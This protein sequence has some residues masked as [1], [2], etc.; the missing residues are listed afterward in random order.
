MNKVTTITSNIDPSQHPALITP[1]PSWFSK[2]IQKIID[3]FQYLFCCCRPG[4]PAPITEHRVVLIPANQAPA[5]IAPI[6]APILLA[7]P[8]A[9]QAPLH[10]LKTNVVATSKTRM[11]FKTDEK[12]GLTT[13]GPTPEMSHKLAAQFLGKGYISGARLQSGIYAF[14][15]ELEGGDPVEIASYLKF[16]LQGQ[17]VK[18]GTVLAQFCD[19]VIA[20][21]EAREDSSRTQFAT[22][23]TQKI[24]HMQPGDQFLVPGGWQGKSGGHALMLFLQRDD[25]GTFTVNVINSGDGAQYHVMKPLS[26]K[27]G[28]K[29]KALPYLRQSQISQKTLS[30]ISVWEFFHDFE[31]DKIAENLPLGPRDFYEG[32]FKMLHP[33]FGEAQKKQCLIEPPADDVFITL[34]AAGTCSADAFFA[35]THFLLKDNKV[36][37][38][39]IKHLLKLQIIQDYFAF[40]KQENVFASHEKNL[41][42]DTIRERYAVLKLFKTY[43]KNFA[44]HVR[45]CQENKWISEQDA[46]ACL[47]LS[48]SMDALTNAAF[49]KYKELIRTAVAPFT[50]LS[51]LPL[52]T[53]P[54][55]KDFE[56][57]NEYKSDP[58]M[59]FFVNTMVDL[60]TVWPKDPADLLKTLQSWEKAANNNKIS[61]H[62]IYRYLNQVIVN[63]PPPG[64][65]WEAVPSKE[66]EEV[67]WLIANLCEKILYIHPSGDLPSLPVFN[68]IYQMEKAFAVVLQL[69]KIFPGEDYGL[70][71]CQINTSPFSYNLF[72]SNYKD[73]YI[74]DVDTDLAKQAM[75]A[76]LKPC[77]S[78]FFN[79]GTPWESL[80]DDKLKGYRELDAKAYQSSEKAFV[81]R[82]L[83]NNKQAYEAAKKEAE[84]LLQNEPL[85]S[86]F[87]DT[88]EYVIF[89]TALSDV[90]GTILP[91]GYCALKKTAM[92]KSLFQRRSFYWGASL[93]FKRKVEIVENGVIFCFKPNMSGNPRYF[94][95]V[96]QLERLIDK[97]SSNSILLHPRF[98]LESELQLIFTTED[99]SHQVLKTLLF[100]KKH[101]S[102]LKQKKYQYI[103]KRLMF[104]HRLLY[105]QLQD[106]PSF[107]QHLVEF[108]QEGFKC[109]LN[110]KQPTE[111]LFFLRIGSYFEK[112]CQRLSIKNANFPNLIQVCD[113]LITKE[114]KEV[115]SHLFLREQLA[116]YGRCTSFD[117]V[118]LSKAIATLIEYVKVKVQFD[119]ENPHFNLELR[120]DII[121]FKIKLYQHFKFVDPKSCEDVLTRATQ[122][123]LNQKEIAAINWDLSKMPLVTGVNAQTKDRYDIDLNVGEFY[124]NEFLISNTLSEHFTGSA[125]FKLIYDRTPRS[126]LKNIKVGKRGNSVQFT[127]QNNQEIRAS[128]SADASDWVIQKLIDNRWHTHAPGFVNQMLDVHFLDEWSY[129]AWREK[130]GKGFQIHQNQTGREVYRYQGDSQRLMAVDPQNLLTYHLSL[131]APSKSKYHSLSKVDCNTNLWQDDLG[132]V[133]AIEYPFGV[134]FKVEYEQG[135][136]DKKTLKGIFVDQPASLQGYFLDPTQSIPS[137][138]RIPFYLVLNNARGEKIVL[139]SKAKLEYGPSLDSNFETPKGAK[140]FYTYHVN[141]NEFLSCDDLEGAIYLIRIELA[142]RNYRI[143]HEMLR[144]PR[145]NK[146]TLYSK[147]EIDPSLDALEIVE[148][149][150]GKFCLLNVSDEDPRAVSLRLKIAYLLVK[151]LNTFASPLK[152]YDGVLK[153][154][155]ERCGEDFIRYLSNM[156]AVGSYALSPDE[157][158]FLLNCMSRAVGGFSNLLLKR[159]VYERINKSFDSK[160][161]YFQLL[162]NPEDAAKDEQSHKSEFV[163]SESGGCN[164]RRM[165]DESYITISTLENIRNSSRWFQFNILNLYAVAISDNIHSTNYLFL[166]NLLKI[167]IISPLEFIRTLSRFCINVMADKKSYP[168]VEDFCE[169]LDKIENQHLLAYIKSEFRIRDEPL[170]QPPP[171]LTLSGSFSPKPRAPKVF[172][173]IIRQGIVRLL[174]PL[175][176]PARLFGI[177]LTETP[178][179]N[180]NI[181]STEKEWNDVRTRIKLL[182]DKTG[183]PS[184]KEQKDLEELLDLES[185]LFQQLESAADQVT[186][187]KYN[188]IAEELQRANQRIDADDN[189]DEMV[190][191]KD[192]LLEFLK[193]EAFFKAAESSESFQLR[194]I[195]HQEE[196][197]KLRKKIDDVSALQKDRVA[198]RTL[199]EL[200]SDVEEFGK[201]PLQPIL[202]LNTT[203]L[204]KMESNLQKQLDFETEKLSIAKKRLLE[205]ANRPP[206]DPKER[207]E[208]ELELEAGIRQK[209]TL[210]DL[211]LKYIRGNSQDFSPITLVNEIENYLIRATRRQ[212]IERSLKALGKFTSLANTEDS[213]VIQAAT[214][215]LYLQ[216]STQ[217]AYDPKQYPELLVTE[218][219]KNILYR[220]EQ[221]AAYEAIL[222]AKKPEVYQHIMGFGKTEAILP[223]LALRK[224]TGENLVCI[225]VAEAQIKEL[226]ARMQINSG[227]MYGQVANRLNWSD[228][229]LDNLKN[230]YK[231]LQRIIKN[232]EF[233][234]V[235]DQE[236]HDFFLQ[237][238]LVRRNRESENA[239][240]EAQGKM[241]EMNMKEARQLVSLPLNRLAH[242]NGIR[243]LLKTKGYA[244][245]DEIDAILRCH[246][247]TLIAVGNPH[248]VNKQAADAAINVFTILLGNF[249]IVKKIYFEFYRHRLG[250]NA[251]PFTLERYHQEVKPI[252]LKALTSHFLRENPSFSKYE[253]DIQKYLQ[254][255]HSPNFTQVL[256]KEF[257]AEKLEELAN[258]R[259]ALHVFLPMTLNQLHNENYG[260]FPTANNGTSTLAGPYQRADTPNIGSQFSHVMAQMF[261]TIQSY[262]KTGITRLQVAA[263]I[264]TLK[265]NIQKEMS[266]SSLITL[267]KT[268]TYQTFTKLVG[269]TAAKKLPLLLL[270]EKDYDT[271][272]THIQ[273]APSQL[274]YYIQHYVFP[275]ISLFDQRIYSNAQTL[276]E[277]FHDMIGVTGTID[278]AET[279]HTRLTTIPT[280]GVNG[281]TLFLMWLNRHQSVRVLPNTETKPLVLLH[282]IL[283]GTQNDNYRVLLDAGAFFKGC[284]Q[285][286][287]A[288]EIFKIYP[289]TAIEAVIFFENDKL[290]LI[291][292][293]APNAVHYNKKNDVP[294]DK[295]FTILPQKHCRAT[296]IEQALNSQALMT[297]N[298]NM[299]RSDA[300][301]SVWRMRGLAKGQKVTSVIQPDLVHIAAQSLQI[302]EK[303]L[304][305]KALETIDLQLFTALNHA[306]HRSEDNL[307]SIHQKLQNVVL[308]AIERLLNHIDVRED[309]HKT[310]YRTLDDLTLQKVGMSA[311]QQFGQSTIEE[312]RKV[313]ET[314]KRNCLTPLVDWIT[315]YKDHQDYLKYQDFQIDVKSLVNEMDK[316]IDES[317]QKDQE[318]VNEQ[319]STRLDTTQDAAVKVSVQMK[320]VEKEREREQNMEIQRDFNRISSSQSAPLESNL[321]FF[322][323]KDLLKTSIFESIRK[324][325][326]LAQKGMELNIKNNGDLRMKKSFAVVP[327]Y[328]RRCINAGNLFPLDLDIAEYRVWNAFMPPNLIL[329][330]NLIYSGE[331]DRPMEPIAKPFGMS[332]IIQ[333]KSNPNN[334]MLIGLSPS[335][336]EQVKQELVAESQTKSERD[337]KEDRDNLLCLYNPG[338][339][340]YQ[341]G[342]EPMDLTIVQNPHFMVLNVLFKFLNGEIYYNDEELKIL[343]SRLRKIGG[344]AIIKTIFLNKLIRNKDVY[345]AYP[346]SPLAAL[347]KSLTSKK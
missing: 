121:A 134:S 9:P 149:E 191:F 264:Q 307:L 22:W 193:T 234:L 318:Y 273:A 201:E 236:L 243:S 305:E 27:K 174:P 92:T 78:G 265:D 196:L 87:K 269:E 302:D 306:Q 311:Y 220:A 271:I 268:A 251:Q 203:Q 336:A 238:R 4:V 242:F 57:P 274:L 98:G 105:K 202:E 64:K 39:Q 211:Y 153:S 240:K 197:S 133:A 143:T 7:A 241:R 263:L 106:E 68:Q 84:L 296:D 90:T 298:K 223:P 136:N 329:T 80:N 32:F 41:S 266:K 239:I 343:E 116:F 29:M 342:K 162:Q 286:E 275:S 255:Q 325:A 205:A 6:I 88:P 44:K 237:A 160:A 131:M 59:D 303:Q 169:R 227:D 209:V 164:S 82:Y 89:G 165:K 323:L 310:L 232:R 91:K 287:L 125:S 154:V 182:Y 73:N 181:E 137:L 183:E 50:T 304:K 97:H 233:L 292:R 332:L 216:L 93:F 74:L 167:S 49:R 297:W 152:S 23:I 214:Q 254:D 231:D 221:I 345:A 320:Q 289:K 8:A 85:K 146:L 290:M 1:P 145:M 260:F 184:E 132:Y 190:A 344:I 83:Q 253:Q 161:N 54:L 207:L 126:N 244:I 249:N 77:N 198:K 245:F 55:T 178:A 76:T 28:H 135:E 40:L 340:I 321:A 314:C 104:E 168:D 101:L 159:R 81:F 157:E 48:K 63:M 109:F 70:K 284:E 115:G 58:P 122:M 20:V 36:L 171:T 170:A 282:Q 204:P 140:G 158:L 247:E 347:F 172:I 250:D 67:M 12:D 166:Q 103:F 293:D 294:L 175:F 2:L 42:I 194:K 129:S 110:Q 46:K 312:A 256:V 72:G 327:G 24:Q 272:A 35:F 99:Q 291:K 38:K 66:M 34:Q 261:F 276:P 279:F 45:N 148:V 19:N 25:D 144:D 53:F 208:F 192:H 179:L 313:L 317:L 86:H 309:M 226:S 213:R 324:E 96:T 10:P 69:S 224:T 62:E 319:L 331:Y 16:I 13:R 147:P 150:A 206:L 33:T 142:Q 30:Q 151:N 37:Y 100:F 277:L 141:S 155:Y 61:T 334:I 26:S 177:S 248:G 15:E 119:Y 180:I 128:V 189:L 278:N 215:D 127:D 107:S 139:I 299:L 163:L 301:Q 14:A 21:A 130:D 285:L 156:P 267:E 316:I 326:Q 51:A 65:Y 188:G 218:F 338:I 52:S 341:H 185:H 270:Q 295:R 252:L 71:D 113:E 283:D 210:D 281:K 120:D 17:Y 112:F 3:L 335:D 11:R 322:L 235:T 228:T 117:N 94:Q 138:Q 337:L 31:K 257:R 173:P 79:D 195:K 339:G 246:D 328:N 114:A 118:N 330:A 229:S 123:I 75:T 288:K 300:D 199:Q 43:K 262:F 315:S 333:S 18:K 56:K 111:A 5:A 186:A 222:K 230:L 259:G 217:R 258:Y 187:R 60:S 108:V 124:L 212:Q 47:A 219:K 225:V 308:Q 176:S 102:L 280:K 200:Q 95:D 346:S